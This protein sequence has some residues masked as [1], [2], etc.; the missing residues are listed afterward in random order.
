MVIRNTKLDAK[1]VG[2]VYGGELLGYSTAYALKYL[3]TLRPAGFMGQ[4]LSFWGDLLGAAGGA[5]GAIYMRAPYSLLSALV[6]GYLATDLVNHIIRLAPVAVATVTATPPTTTAV[7]IPPG[8]VETVQF[9][10]RKGYVYDMQ[11]MGSDATLKKSNIS[12]ILCHV[13]ILLK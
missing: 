8:T 12:S 1:D 4:P 11:Y 6:G 5:L 9:N 3:D 7:F 13:P 2:V 10:Q